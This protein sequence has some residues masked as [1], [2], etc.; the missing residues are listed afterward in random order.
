MNAGQT[1]AMTIVA[2]IA[3]GNNGG[4]MNEATREENNRKIAEWLGYKRQVGTRGYVWYH[5]PTCKGTGTSENNWNGCDVERHSKFLPDFYSD[6]SANA[7]LLEKMPRPSLTR[8][9]DSG[10]W[11]C[12]ADF[13]TFDEPAEN[14]NRKTAICSAFIKWKDSQ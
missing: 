2:R 11:S 3:L 12:L 13:L 1:T 5:S 7:L 9:V 8:F 4:P 14:P 10:V 6:E